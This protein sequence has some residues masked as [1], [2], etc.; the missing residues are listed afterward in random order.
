V[1]LWGG[2]GY[3]AGHIVVDKTHFQDMMAR[4]VRKQA[5]AAILQLKARPHAR[6][7]T[8]L[9]HLP[10]LITWSGGQAGKERRAPIQST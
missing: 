5:D 2:G 1:S 4:E 8:S 9:S 6:A 7:T 10:P 3:T